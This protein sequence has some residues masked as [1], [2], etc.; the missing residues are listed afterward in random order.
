M[1]I[2]TSTN[3]SLVKCNIGGEM[4]PASASSPSPV[5]VSTTMQGQYV[6]QHMLQQMKRA[7]RCVTSAGSQTTPGRCAAGII[8]ITVIIVVVIIV[9]VV[10]LHLNQRNSCSE[11]DILCRS[12]MIC[13]MPCRSAIVSVTMP[14]ASALGSA[15]LEACSEPEHDTRDH[16]LK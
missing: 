14:S 5:S 2:A 8:C 7:S 9:A 4:G 6:S 13:D 11:C 1:T 10:A 12:A 3:K 16:K 15:A